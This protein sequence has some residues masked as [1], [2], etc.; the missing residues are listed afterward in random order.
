MVRSG[1][2]GPGRG[3]RGRVGSGLVIVRGGSRAAR[4]RRVIRSL[5][6]VVVRIEPM[7]PEG[8][9][10]VRAVRLR[11]LVDVPGAFATTLEEEEARAAEGWWWGRFAGPSAATF[12]ATLGGEDVGI[13]TGAEHRRRERSVGRFGKSVAPSRGS[14]V[15][16]PHSWRWSSPGHGR[17]DTSGSCSRWGPRTPPRSGSLRASASLRPAAPALALRPGSI[18]ASRSWRWSCEPR[19]LATRRCGE[20]SA[21]A[22]GQERHRRR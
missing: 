18:T 14:A 15:W 3:S 2:S 11:A 4:L 22:H 13:V 10:R 12:Q 16:P 19:D 9:E 5:R 6:A 21:G 7:A 1:P 20:R 8:W 17:L